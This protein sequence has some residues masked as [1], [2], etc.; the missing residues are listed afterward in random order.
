MVQMQQLLENQ[1]ENLSQIEIIYP[2]VWMD[3]GAWPLFTINFY[4]H[5]TGDFDILF[6]KQ[7]YFA[8]KFSHR[9]KKIIKDMEYTQIINYATSQM[10][11]IMVALLNI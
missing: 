6:E 7:I 11:F 8:D 10:K 4:I 3:H 2:R 5:Q 9:S 1:K